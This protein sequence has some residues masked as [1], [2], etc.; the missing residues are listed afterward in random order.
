MAMKSGNGK[1]NKTMPVLG[2]LG[3]SLRLFPKL[4][5]NP[6]AVRLLGLN[7]R[8]PLRFLFNPFR[9]SRF[10]G[11][12]PNLLIAKRHPKYCKGSWIS[13]AKGNTLYNYLG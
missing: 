5:P 7:T 4:R 1:H 9:N 12:L 10:Q 6:R 11:L 2:R 8:Q 3:S 13:D